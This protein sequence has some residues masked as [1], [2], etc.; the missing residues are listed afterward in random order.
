[1]HLWVVRVCVC[2]CCV[3]VRAV[4]VCV[5]VCVCVCVGVWVCVCVRAREQ[6]S[7]RR[8]LTS[9]R[10]HLVV[11]QDRATMKTH[12]INHVRTHTGE[13]P[14][15]CPHCDCECCTSS[16][17]VAQRACIFFEVLMQPSN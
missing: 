3:C 4:C 5:L 17:I 7:T 6:C 14:F 12:L 1:V 10:H 8:L 2:A 16:I 9:L 13:R 11:L 15:A